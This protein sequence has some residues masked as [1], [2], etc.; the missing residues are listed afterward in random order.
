MQGG[1]KFRIVKV[2]SMTRTPCCKSQTSLKSLLIA[3]LLLFLLACS[4]R[5]P[6]EKEEEQYPPAKSRCLNFYIF[7]D[8]IPA[9]MPESMLRRSSMIN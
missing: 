6:N 9:L 8:G 3:S 5:K 1:T 2:E 4:R 7:P